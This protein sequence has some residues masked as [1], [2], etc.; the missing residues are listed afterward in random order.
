MNNPKNAIFI[1]GYQDEESPGRR[2]LGLKTG[3]AWRFPDGEE[4]TM[5]CPG[6]NA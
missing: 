5:A 6:V 4:V 2:L 1:T 3:D